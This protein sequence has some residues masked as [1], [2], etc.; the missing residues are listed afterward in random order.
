MTSH[1]RQPPV[2]IPLTLDQAIGGLLKVDP[3][4]PPKKAV[5]KKSAPKRAAPKKIAKRKA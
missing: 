5:A 4:Q 1:K 2:H 3:E